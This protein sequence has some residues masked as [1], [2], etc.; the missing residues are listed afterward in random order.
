MERG[1]KREF[2]RGRGRTHEVKEICGPARLIR[3]PGGE[4]SEANSIGKQEEEEKEGEE[5]R[6]S[7]INEKIQGTWP[8]PE[9]RWSVQKRGGSADMDFKGH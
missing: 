1:R 6:Q 5:R 8:S 9:C 3:W 2:P 4:G 7:G